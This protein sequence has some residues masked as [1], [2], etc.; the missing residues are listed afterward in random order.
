MS[1][2]RVVNGDMGISDNNEEICRLLHRLCLFMKG[3]KSSPLFF[4]FLNR[5]L[6]N[7]MDPFRFIV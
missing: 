7:Y 6:Q 3:F 1:L 2:R 5:D 4:L